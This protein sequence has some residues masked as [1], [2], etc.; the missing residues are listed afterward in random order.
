MR[1]LTAIQ[2]NEKLRKEFL[3]L[4]YAPR[5]KEIRRIVNAAIKNRDLPADVKVT[6]FLD[7][8]VGP[9]LARLLFRQERIDEPFVEAVF[10]QA[11]AGVGAIERD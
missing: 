8:I 5:E 6:V 7:S 3:K 11:V 4:V 2:D 10:K 1:L 9:L